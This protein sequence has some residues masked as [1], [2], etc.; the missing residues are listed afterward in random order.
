[1]AARRESDAEAVLEQAS[2]D[3]QTPLIRRDSGS[4][5]PPTAHVQLSFR[6]GLTI[7]LTMGSLIF[8]Q[9]I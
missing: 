3:E 9:G 6:R 8:I 4:V 1:M 5:E 2:H 7:L